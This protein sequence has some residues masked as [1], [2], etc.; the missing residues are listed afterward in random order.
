[1][2][3][4]PLPNSLVSGTYRLDAAGAIDAS[5][6]PISIAPASLI[7]E[8]E[9]GRIRVVAADAPAAIDGHPA[10]AKATV[11]SMP[12]H[13]LTPAL[14][15]SHT[16]LDLTHIGP[17]PHSSF[18]AFVDLVRSARHVDAAAIRESL[19]LGARLSRAGGVGAVGDIAGAVRGGAS[20][21]PYLALRDS[22]LAGV[23]FLEFFAMGD[24]VSRALAR[25]DEVTDAATAMPASKIRFGLQPHAPY[26]V[27]CVGYRHALARAARDR[28]PIA[29]HLAES[30]EEH[31]FISEARGPQR[32]L[33]EGLGL[34]NDSLLAE[35]GLGK[36]PVAHLAGAL[37]ER[38]TPILLVHLNDLSDADVELLAEL[39]TH[40]PIHVAYCP[41]ASEFFGAPMTF[42]PHRYR[43]LIAAGINVCLGTD[44]IVNLPESDA[45]GAHARISPVDDARLLARRDNTDAALLL[46][47]MT[48]GGAVALG[49]DA[50]AFSLAPGSNVGGVCTWKIPADV[51]PRATS[52]ELW[53]RVLASEILPTRL[54]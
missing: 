21:E 25:V 44:S 15:N 13:L 26:S 27:A 16:H 2:N 12:D 9:P 45:A 53:K 18:A 7:L 33:L 30:T 19:L 22:E 42:G 3:P 31:A 43:E 38:S 6:K 32:S 8:V 35:Y 11:I 5:A 52:G 37:R 20:I 4:R 47:M 40:V 34:W 24:S 17:K 51:G 36:T 1:M 41:R 54:I 29:T 28:L 50:N 10:A 49:L 39:N 48:A 14:V 23:S 46:N